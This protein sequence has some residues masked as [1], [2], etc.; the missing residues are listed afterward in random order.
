MF[1]AIKRALGMFVEDGY[2]MYDRHATECHCWLDGHRYA[3]LG[4]IQGFLYYSIFCCR[5]VT[6]RSLHNSPLIFS[7]K[8]NFGVDTVHAL[9]KVTMC[10]ISQW[11]LNIYFYIFLFNRC[12][13]VIR[14]SPCL[15]LAVFF[16]L[17]LLIVPESSRSASSTIPFKKR[18][19][20]CLN[21]RMTSPT[22]MRAS[23]AQTWKSRH[24]KNHRNCQELSER[25]NSRFDSITERDPNEVV[26]LSCPERVRW[27]HRQRTHSGAGSVFYT[28]P[29]PT[30]NRRLIDQKS[31]GRDFIFLLLSFHTIVSFYRSRSIRSIEEK[32][33]VISTPN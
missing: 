27:Y 9:A 7:N 17:P 10:C 30:L 22:L 21:S 20:H 23:C 25:T 11:L 32:A 15:L 19:R 29:W 18:V 28:W 1:R 31:A 24:T 26:W 16:W 3:R 12:Q 14:N 4:G 5:R 33:Q 8:R 6:A 13:T 2:V